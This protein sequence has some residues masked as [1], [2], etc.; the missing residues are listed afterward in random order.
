MSSD[1][2]RRAIEETQRGL[3]R[4]SAE[5]AAQL[6]KLG[7][8]L[9][10]REGEAFS[11]SSMADVHRG[12]RELREQL[13]RS[14]Q[15]VKRIVQCVGRSEELEAQMRELKV[16]AAEIEARNDELC[17]QI[18]RSAFAAYSSAFAARGGAEEQQTEYEQVFGALIRLEEE[19][20]SLDREQERLQSNVRTGNFFRIF[21]ETGRSLYL[22]GLLSLKK[23]SASRSYREAGQRFCESGLAAAAD[24]PAL[25][26]ALGPYRE[27]RRRLQSINKQLGRFREEQAALWEELKELGAEKSHQRRVRELEASIQRIDESLEDAFE[28]LGSLFRAKPVKA[29]AED[30]EVAHCLRLLSRAERSSALGRKRIERLEAALQIEQLARQ[31]QSLEEKVDRLEREIRTRQEEIALLRDEISETGA[32]SERLA[33]LRGSEESLL[34]SLGAQ[35]AAEEPEE[36]A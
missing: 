9:S 27:N 10:Y 32:Q 31:R 35:A 7:E 1:A 23:K 30:L 19:I 15:E 13:P 24:D 20:E 36:Q 5:I 12:I 33:R 21:R 28:G 26:R 16:Q 3:Q 11:D 25:Q 14:R 17:E 8:H 22:K 34:R 4:N 29:L 6:K 18:G 2:Y